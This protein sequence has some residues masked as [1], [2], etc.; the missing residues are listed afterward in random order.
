MSDKTRAPLHEQAAD[1][2][3]AAR[4]Q[5]AT[6]VATIHNDPIEHSVSLI[7]DI[8]TNN[9]IPNKFRVQA[10]VH[11]I[12]SRG[13]GGNDLLIQQ[14]CTK[15]RRQYVCAYTACLRQKL[16]AGKSK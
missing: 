13:V 11:S 10:R 4:P 8:L 16:T 9:T 12:I 7:S 1:I 3:N 6:H 2:I 5:L 14:H 15:C